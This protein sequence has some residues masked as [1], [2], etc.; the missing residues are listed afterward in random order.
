[1]FFQHDNEVE[2]T[3]IYEL[4]KFLYIRREFTIIDPKSFVQII[5]ILADNYEIRFQTEFLKF[6]GLVLDMKLL[7]LA[8]ER[9][10]VHVALKPDDFY[11]YIANANLLISESSLN[12][13]LKQKI[14]QI[15]MIYKAIYEYQIKRNNKRFT[16]G[17]AVNIKEY[18]FDEIKEFEELKKLLD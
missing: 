18:F 8:N 14:Y 3:L 2:D 7:L 9:N 4:H 6:I 16:Q 15:G 5:S 10:I 13:I 17:D 1:M 11:D 12:K